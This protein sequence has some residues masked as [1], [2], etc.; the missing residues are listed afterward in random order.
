MANYPR[1]RKPWNRKRIERKQ[2]KFSKLE[3]A[4]AFL[5]EAKRE[6]VRKGGVR[7]GYD[8]DLHYDFMRAVE[9]LAG[10]AGGTLW[11]AA[12]VYRQ[13]VSA[14]EYRGGKYEVPIDRKVELNPR[15]FLVVDGEAGRMQ[16]TVG[17][18]LAMII[19]WWVEKE[20]VKA[21][22]E[23]LEAE[24]AEVAEIRELRKAY[25]VLVEERKNLSVALGQAKR[26]RYNARRRALWHLRKEIAEVKERAFLN[27]YRVSIE[28][29]EEGDGS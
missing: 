13:S 7:L 3:E 10:I 18:A 6:W 5:E 23:R 21:I 17:N 4:E 25:E 15:E 16:T 2:K 28:P 12:L 1:D 11:K 26:D 27:G 14:R 8:R 19:G 20:A 22:K 29:L 9:E 24:R